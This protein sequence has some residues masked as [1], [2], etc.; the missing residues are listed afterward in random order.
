MP[1]RFA[2]RFSAR[3]CRAAARRGDWLAPSTDLSLGPLSPAELR[4]EA[5]DGEGVRRGLVGFYRA[6]LVNDRL[7]TPE[8]FAAAEA[9]LLD[10]LGE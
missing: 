5:P 1:D 9:R 3:P 4:A 8:R 7:D 2:R 10:R 6:L